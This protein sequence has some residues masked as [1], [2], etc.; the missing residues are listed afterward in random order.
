MPARSYLP[1]SIIMVGVGDGPWD[2]MKD[3]DDALPQ[4]QFD[5]FQ[6]NTQSGRCSCA[7]RRCAVTL[8]GAAW[9]R[10]TVERNFSGDGALQQS[11]GGGQL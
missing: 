10:C 3:F 7:E 8:H 11:G 4:R 2:L 1:M 5:N 9:M 6:V